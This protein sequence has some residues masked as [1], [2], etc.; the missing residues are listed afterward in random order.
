VREA[1]RPPSGTLHSLYNALVLTKPAP[2]H[3]SFL[4]FQS[5]RALRRIVQFVVVVCI[6][7]GLPPADRSMFLLY[8]CFLLL[9]FL[10]PIAQPNAIAHTMM[11]MLRKIS[12]TAVSL[13]LACC[14]FACPIVLG[15]FRGRHSLRISV[16]TELIRLIVFALTLAPSCAPPPKEGSFCAALPQPT[17]LRD[18]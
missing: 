13:A 17:V 2:L 18:C 1:S 14:L 4:T 6:V 3:S 15:V 16:R 9:C 7:A 10:Y 5:L 11:R 8:R 12:G